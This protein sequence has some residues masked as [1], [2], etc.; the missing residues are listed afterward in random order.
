MRRIFYVAEVIIAFKSGDK[1]RVMA[2]DDGFVSEFK[3]ESSS[4]AI[5]DYKTG[6]LYFISKQHVLYIEVIREE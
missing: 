2:R 4:F 6:E 1:L 5:K 3:S